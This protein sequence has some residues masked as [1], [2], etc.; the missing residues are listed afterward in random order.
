MWSYLESFFLDII[1]LRMLKSCIIWVEPKSSENYSY[2]GDK[3]NKFWG[4]N[5]QSNGYNQ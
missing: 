1:K 2:K 4:A 3:M 5:V